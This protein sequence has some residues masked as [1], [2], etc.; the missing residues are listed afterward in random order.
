MSCLQYRSNAKSSYCF[1]F[2]VA[3]IRVREESKQALI[4]AGNYLKILAGE[5]RLTTVIK[6]TMTRIS[7]TYK[8]AHQYTEWNINLNLKLSSLSLFQS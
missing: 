2:Y 4:A 1:L 3:L 8:H 7:C 6:S 5:I